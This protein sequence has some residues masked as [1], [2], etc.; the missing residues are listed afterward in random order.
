MAQVLAKI[1]E[2]FS[3]AFEIRDDRWRRVLR[4]LFGFFFVLSLFFFFL[5]IVL[6]GVMISN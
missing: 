2:C 3:I 6:I 5:S 4:F 1:M